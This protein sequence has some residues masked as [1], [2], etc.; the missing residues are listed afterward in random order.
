[1][2]DHSYHM[3][4]YKENTKTNILDNHMTSFDYTLY[5]AD[6]VISKVILQ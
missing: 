6:Y 3:I 1:M 5:T 4:E 2:L